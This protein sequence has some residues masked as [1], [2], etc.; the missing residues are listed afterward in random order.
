M[1]RVGFAVGSPFLGTAVPIDASARKSSKQV[2]DYIKEL[3]QVHDISRVVLGY[4]L[5]MD[6]SRSTLCEAVEHFARRLKRGLDIPV[7]LVDERLSSFEAEEVLKT[8][9][10]DYKKRKKMIDSMSATVILR[11]FMESG[12]T[13]EIPINEESQSS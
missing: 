7:A 10:A 8:L 5:N 11:R 9:K 4:P 6:G 12:E 3:I 2:I 1:K 13:L